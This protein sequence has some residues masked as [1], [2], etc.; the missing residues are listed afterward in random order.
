KPW[1]SVYSPDKIQL[2]N[3]YGITETPVHV[4][5]HRLTATEILEA[6]GISPIGRPLPE[7]TVYLFDQYQKL[8]P[9]G[10]VGE[11]YVGGTGVGQGYLNRPD[12][13]EQRFLDNPYR[14][15]ERLYKSGDLGRWNP[16][17]RLEYL[18]RNDDQVQIRGYRVELGEIEKQ[19]LNHPEVAEAVVLAKRLDG[20][21]QELVAYLVPREISGGAE[22]L[23]VTA[24]RD[25]LSRNLPDYMIPG[26]FIPL[27]KLPLTVNGKIDK[28]ALPHPLEAG[29][30]GLRLGT[31]YHPPQNES[32]EL[33]A[34]V[35]E[36]VL[37]RKPIG[38]H[39]NF[40]VLGGDS[41]KAIQI[42]SRL[43]QKQYKVELRHIFEHPTIAQLARRMTSQDR[44]IDQDTVAGRMPLTA[45]QSWFWAEHKTDRQH[46][47]QAVLLGSP[48]GTD[49]HGLA[50]VLN[51]IQEHHDALRMRYRGTGEEL[52]Q[53]IAALDYPL[54]FEIK[55]LRGFL[56]TGDK[57]AA[58]CAAVPESLDL[59]AGPMMKV[60]LFRL[61]DGDRLLIVIHHLVVDGVSWRILLEDLNRG[62]AQ[63]LS[64]SPI[65]FPDKTDSFK[66]WAERIHVYANQAE[67]LEETSFWGSLAPTPG[68]RLSNESGLADHRHQDRETLTT[69]L[70]P[71]LTTALL[72]T[73]N[74][75]YRTEINDLLLTA[76][77]RA[78]S[79]QTGH[80]ALVIDLEGH[81]R[82]DIIPDVDISRTVGW[83]TSLYPVGL[84]LSGVDDP[85]RQIRHIKDTLR[86]IPHKGIGYGLLKYI[87]SPENKSDLNFDLKPEIGFNYLGRFDTEIDEGWWRLIPEPV[88]NQV[89]PLVERVHP[90][91]I[92]GLV[93]DGK[94]E[95]S[96]A[97]PRSRLDRE[98]A[99]NLLWA[100]EEELRTLIAHCNNRLSAG[101][102]P[103]DFTFQD[104]SSED[105]TQLLTTY[106]IAQDNLTDIYPLSPM[107]E[108]MLYHKLYESDSAAYF[109]QLSWPITGRLD[110]AAFQA[111]WDSLL[112][113]HDVFKTVFIHKGTPLPL[114]LVLKERRMDFAFEDLSLL[115]P[116]R[117]QDVL[118]AARQ[119]DFAKGFDL[120]RDVLMRV[121]LFK[122]GTKS[123]QVIW[124]HHHI[125]MDGWC[126]SII[127]NE[128]LYF[129]Q[130][131]T[132][133]PVSPELAPAVP[134][135]GYI[136]WLEE[137]N[138]DADRDYWASY[139]AGYERPA[140]IPKLG[141]T[142]D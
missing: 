98:S 81:G 116:S 19:L 58:A 1:I 31:D 117:Q 93:L 60:I 26:Y 113:R 61:D 39:D 90:I 17:G 79:R 84:D 72:T 33:L 37:I 5:Y 57:L 47:T 71:D 126:L 13:T 14:P 3:M 124:S 125:T 2:I 130:A 35:W 118:A 128:L 23:N 106:N 114:Q 45:I 110:V 131:L 86:R 49:A 4:T 66:T 10:A 50:A 129:Y 135:R 70:T 21:V 46:F 30:T 138:R 102:A 123:Y 40:F 68:P 62:Y 119:H 56:Q 53:D 136:K 103:G 94:L 34:A 43:H 9:L 55:D 139:L 24:L 73:A 28:A 134:Y 100:F 11:I 59:A 99:Q 120:S 82:E 48:A 12:L 97:Y 140:S 80:Q 7:T 25:Y 85:G 27:A 44:T 142:H 91:E 141:H 69:T 16:D 127:I 121:K 137:Q 75:A 107:Q 67:L 122:L 88:N 111:S 6:T 18:G 52:I 38:I 32:E 22:G 112:N 8:V 77:A 76:L 133:G 101:P 54:S 74:K 83:F 108:G 63:F 15:G 104:L 105:L 65:V 64:G 109:E 95:L 96:L 87:T 29:Q 36:A 92:E 115:D 51:K 20:E 42:A 132:H 78:V 89:G 41:I